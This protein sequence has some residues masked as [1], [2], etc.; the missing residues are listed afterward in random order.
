MTENDRNLLNP[1]N[2]DNARP[3]TEEEKEVRK[4]IALKKKIK[5][6][7]ADPAVAEMFAIGLEAE[8]RND[9]E[10][11]EGAAWRI[12]KQ[13]YAK[14]VLDK[15]KAEDNPAPVSVPPGKVH[16]PAPASPEPVKTDKE[17]CPALM[18]K[19]ELLELGW[20]KEQIA[21]VKAFPPRK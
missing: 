21:Q 17:F 5:E 9:P 8:V 19:Q 11:L 12:K 10:L 20:T 18:S 7:K 1:E 15:M 14:K 6:L 16:T 4:E 3:E 13:E 2:V